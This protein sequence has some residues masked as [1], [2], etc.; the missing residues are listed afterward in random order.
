MG[1]MPQEEQFL[2]WYEG[3]CGVGLL[4]LQIDWHI[5]KKEYKP[6]SKIRPGRLCVTVRSRVLAFSLEC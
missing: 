4:R 5:K 2:G 6:K 3:W 1:Q